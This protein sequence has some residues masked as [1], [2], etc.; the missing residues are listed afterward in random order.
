MKN[1]TINTK[2]INI[3]TRLSSNVYVGHDIEYSKFED[4][5]KDPNKIEKCCLLYRCVTGQ[6][7]KLTSDMVHVVD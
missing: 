4:M 3:P 7:D 6:T 5:I 2:N 1:V